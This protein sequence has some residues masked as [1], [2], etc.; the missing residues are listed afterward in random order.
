MSVYLGAETQ[1]AGTQGAGTQGAG[2]KKK[3]SKGKSGENIDSTEGQRNNAQDAKIIEAINAKG[4]YSCGKIKKFSNSVHAILPFRGFSSSHF[5]MNRIDG[6]NFLTK[7]SFYRKSTPEIYGAEKSDEQNQLDVEIKILELFREKLLDAGV[8]SC[9]IRMIHHVECSGELKKI[10]NDGQFNGMICRTPNPVMNVQ[11][12]IANMFCRSADLYAKGMMEDKYCF[13]CLETSDLTFRQF[14]K[15]YINDGLLSFS[16]FRAIIFQIIF[17]LRQIQRRWPDFRH[18]DLHSDNV[19]ITID[20]DFTYN[21]KSI[22]YLLFERGGKKYYIPY[23]G[24]IPKLIDFGFSEI[25]SAGIKSH[26]LSDKS[27]M[28]N[29]PPSDILFLFHDINY[30][31]NIERGVDLIDS[32]DP[33]GFY[34]NFDAEF[35]KAN[36]GEIPTLDEM[37][38]NENWNDYIEGS[39]DSYPAGNIIRSYSV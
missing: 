2:R 32:L 34:Y 17:T 25:P 27:I 36:P 5:F 22:K 10:S 16:I 24:L 31:L 28:F 3:M 4:I 23:Y 1:G 39:G 7:L 37:L 35:L 8:T 20:R 6:V 38:D 15:R 11:Q 30:I 12:T 18:N 19:L 26:I 29:R 21:D 13:I 33:T 9:I 14:I